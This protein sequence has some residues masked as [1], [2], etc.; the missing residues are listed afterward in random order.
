MV[1][2][3]PH[4]GFFKSA[5]RSFLEETKQSAGGNGHGLVLFGEMVS[6]LWEEG[7]HAGALAL[8]SLWNEVL[9][10]KPL[11]LHCA[12]PRSLFSKDTAGLMDICESHSHIVGAN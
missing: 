7:N 6:V 10:E 5:V 1:R 11:H 2:G 8:E 12:Y 3:L 4:T 9:S